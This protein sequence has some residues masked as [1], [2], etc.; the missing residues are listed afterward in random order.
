MQTETNQEKEVK[1]SI[2]VYVHGIKKKCRK[3]ERHSFKLGYIDYNG[4][5]FDKGEVSQRARDIVATNMKTVCSPISVQMLRTEW[6]KDD[7]GTVMTFT[8]FDERHVN[9]KIDTLLN[10]VLK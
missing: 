1:F 5:S 3:S 9:F 8:M 7:Y 4:G 10:E 6:K 2:T